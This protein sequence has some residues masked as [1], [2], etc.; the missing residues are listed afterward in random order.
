MDQMKG[1]ITMNIKI[2]GK[3]YPYEP[4]CNSNPK[5]PSDELF[6]RKHTPGFRPTIGQDEK[7]AN[8]KKAKQYI[9][10]THHIADKDDRYK[11]QRNQI[12]NNR[13]IRYDF[14]EKRNHTYPKI[15]RFNLMSRIMF[16]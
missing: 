6:L 9:P 4:D 16:F 7:P 14:R 2:V 5:N 13:S 1:A 8:P 10:P 12:E 15:F 3:D 11:G